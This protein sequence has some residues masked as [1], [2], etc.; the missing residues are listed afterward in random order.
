DHR[1]SENPDW[2]WFFSFLQQKYI[3]PQPVRKM[4]KGRKLAFLKNFP[5]YR[6][7]GCKIS[8]YFPIAKETGVISGKFELHYK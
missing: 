1:Q 3:V 5:L 4:G 8:K 6:K 2:L 7:Q